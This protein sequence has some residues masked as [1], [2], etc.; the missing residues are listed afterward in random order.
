MI[1]KVLKSFVRQSFLINTKN[2]FLLKYSLETISE[3]NNFE[4]NAGAS[5]I[6]KKKLT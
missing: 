6:T 3:N 2:K 1:L 5:K 4:K